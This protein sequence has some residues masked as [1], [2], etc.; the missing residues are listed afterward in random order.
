M[1]LRRRPSTRLPRNPA[2]TIIAAPARLGVSPVAPWRDRSSLMQRYASTVGSR[3]L[4]RLKEGGAG[5][6]YRHSASGSSG[7]LPAAGRPAA[8]QLGFA[9]DSVPLREMTHKERVATDLLL[10]GLAI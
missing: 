4:T 5:P 2:A 1:T 7:L 3:A 9:E 8:L 6:P 10:L